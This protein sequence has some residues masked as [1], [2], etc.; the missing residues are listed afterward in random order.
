MCKYL[1]QVVAQLFTLTIDRRP[2]DI[3]A[4]KG[5]SEIHHIVEKYFRLQVPANR[6]QN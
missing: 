2:I 6:L 3:H 1:K 5:T 4:M